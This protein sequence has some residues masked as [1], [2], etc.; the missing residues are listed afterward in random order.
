MDRLLTQPDNRGFSSS[1]R[2][3]A[4]QR[5]RLRTA[6]LGFMACRKVQLGSILEVSAQRWS[7]TRLALGALGEKPEVIQQLLAF[8]EGAESSIGCDR[9]TT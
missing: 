6:Q 3:Q 4:L 8:W 9:F 5:Q 1:L 7:R 2:A